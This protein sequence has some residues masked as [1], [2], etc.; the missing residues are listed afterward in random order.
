MKSKS[1]AKQEELH[2]AQ[3]MQAKPKVELGDTDR[4]KL[5]VL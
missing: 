4:Y 3:P 5:I 1:E 2:E